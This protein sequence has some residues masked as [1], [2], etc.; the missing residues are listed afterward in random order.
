M[1]TIVAVKKNG[2][3]AIA[4]DTLTMWGNMKESSEHITNNEKILKFQDN[5]LGFT[6]SSSF[7]LVVEHWLKNVKRK[8]KFESV[9]DIFESWLSFHQQL[10]D[11]YYL[12][13]EDEDS[14]EFE[15]SRM[16]VLI[17]NPK[18]VFAV[19][20]LRSV[21]EYK[22]FTAFGSGC[23]YAIGAMR[24]VYDDPAKSAEDIAKI[25]I[26]IAAEFDDATAL[27]MHCYTVKL[28]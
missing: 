6:G 7:K 23:D 18:G 9:E 22:R 3:A 15:T 17:L 16:N 4:A 2:Y 12:R 27:P 26:G 28:K 14:D 24:A 20:V 5:Y 11:K 19:G 13:A 21:N 1:T 10:K 8:P 25:G